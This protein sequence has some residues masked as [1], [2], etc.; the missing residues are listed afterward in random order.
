MFNRALKLD[1]NNDDS[2]LG[3]WYTSGDNNAAN[4]NPSELCVSIDL[5]N[6]E[7]HFEYNNGLYVDSNTI[8]R[9]I[10][11]IAKEVKDNV[12]EYKELYEGH[13]YK[14]SF[15]YNGTKIT[16]NEYINDKLES[17]INVFNYDVE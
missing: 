11:G 6:K 8:G 14:L 2:G 10:I 7:F 13:E 16:I 9:Y 1:L 17:S 12:Y 3:T 15:E 4:G 5:A